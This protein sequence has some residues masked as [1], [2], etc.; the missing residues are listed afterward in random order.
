M[1]AGEGVHGLQRALLL[2]GSRTQVVSLWKVDDHATEALNRLKAL[3]VQIAIDDF[4]T[5]YSS[6]SYLHQFPL[7]TLKIDRVFVNNMDKSESSL[8]I[9]ASIAHLAHEL[10]MD[11]VAEG[12]EEEAQMEALRDLG[13]QLGQGYFMS[14]PLP[15]DEALKLI[16]S[17]PRW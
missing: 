8:R 13:C 16:E 9:V 3:G 10:G 15:G 14:K 1:D 12:I 4:G 17:A 2:A 6:L 7:D 11:I 5:G